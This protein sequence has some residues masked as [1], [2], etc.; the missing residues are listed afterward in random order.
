MTVL[1]LPASPTEDSPTVLWWRKF[2]RVRS[3]LWPCLAAMVLLGLGFWIRTALDRVLSRSVA[4]QLTTVRDANVEAL[5]IWLKNQ[6][7]SCQLAAESRRVQSAAVEV[8]ESFRTQPPGA[9]PAIAPREQLLS[10]LEPWLTNG[11]FEGFVLLDRDWNMVAASFPE[12]LGR[13][14][15]LEYGEFLDPVFSG[16]AV[17]SRPFPSL[18]RQPTPEGRLRAGLPTMYA[19]AP[20]IQDGQ[21]VGALALRIRPDLDFTRILQV[22]RLGASGETYAFDPAGLLISDGR[23]DQQLRSYGLL[24]DSPDSRSILTLTIRDPGVDLTRGERPRFPRDELPLTSGVQRAIDTR[25]PGVDVQG[26]RDYFGIPSVGAWTWLEE[27]RFGVI[28]EVNRDEAYAPAVVIRRF[29]WGLG[30][31][32]LLALTAILG[33][34][35]LLARWRKTARQAVLVAQ[36]LGQYTLEEQIGAGGMG[37]VFRAHHAM[38]RRPTAVK[39]LDPAKTNEASLKRFEREVRLTSQ[40]NHPNTVAIYDYG[41]TP[42][43]LFY[44]AMELLDGLTLHDLVQRDG[45]QPAGRV[46]CLLRQICGS[47]AEAHAMGLIHRDIK[48]ANVLVNQR[49]G[50]SD[51]I[52]V[53]DFGLVK[54][55]FGDEARITRANAITGTP[56][57]MAPE[58]IDPTQ[59]VDHRVDL[60][61]VGGVGYYLISGLELFEAENLFQLLRLQSTTLPDPPSLRSGV[62]IPADLERVIM[63]CL[64]KAP[65]DRPGSAEE[66]DRL[67]AACADASSWTPERAREWWRQYLSKPAASGSAPSPTIPVSP[68]VVLRRALPVSEN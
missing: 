20:L 29:V 7:H 36:Q 55:Q 41:R 52:K 17:V 10:S 30:S 32:L 25:E 3:W 39:L 58:S 61:A 13:Q 16:S 46:I 60:Y 38:L 49:G 11:G 27:Y 68:T 22:G 9:P 24:P 40:L 23:F 45:P 59:E 34:T 18:I 50:M 57:Y 19:C 37:T 6:K 2:N 54:D 51:V 62:G 5:Q 33:V 56:L 42:E 67:L 47:L 65:Q 1:P 26:Y 8:L 66:L 53:V 64:A 4:E 48:P 63:K 44:Y 31:L 43:G 14:A 12:L 21:I 15:P 35:R 28:T